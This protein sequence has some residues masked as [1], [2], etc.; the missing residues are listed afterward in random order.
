MFPKQRVRHFIK[1]ISWRLVG[2]VD[3]ILLVFI[4][5]YFQFSSVNGAAEVAISMFSIEVIT[6]MI[7]YCAHERV[8]FISNYGVKK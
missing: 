5:F 2:A 3:T 8:W 7:L 6:K 1:T 4:V